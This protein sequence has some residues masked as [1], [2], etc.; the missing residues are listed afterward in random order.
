MLECWLTRPDLP[1]LDIYVH[2]QFFRE[3]LAPKY[4]SYIKD[5]LNVNVHVG[6]LPPDAFARLVAG[7]AFFLC[8][9]IQEGYGHYMN[10]ARAANG[11]IVTT[12]APPMNELVT[13]DTGV[14]IPTR[15]RSHL[16]Q[17]LGGEHQGPHGLRGVEGMVALLSR[18]GVCDAVDAVIKQMTPVERERKA[19]NARVAYLRDQRV[20]ADKMKAIRALVRKHTREIVGR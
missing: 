9:S 13:E 3:R 18:Q 20:F 5:S 16:N 8:P 2:E 4:L 7:S 11:L 14:L 15:T 6:E 17:L 10:Q 19:R 12:D 1:T